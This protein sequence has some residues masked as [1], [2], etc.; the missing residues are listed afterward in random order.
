MLG[1]F[2]LGRGGVARIYV[3]VTAALLVIGM[4]T[5]PSD[6]RRYA[7]LYA[8]GAIAMAICTWFLVQD[9]NASIHDGRVQ[10]SHDLM[11]ARFCGLPKH[12]LLV[13]WGDLYFQYN[14]LY[15]QNAGAAQGCNLHLYSV[16]SLQLAPYSTDNL[17]Q[18]TGY[19]SVVEAL[20]NGRT[21]YMYTRPYELSF[22]E[23]YLAEHYG[24]KLTYSVAT[25][26]Y[27]NLNVYAVQATP[28]S[29][30]PAPP[31]G[32]PSNEM[33]WPKRTVFLNQ[34]LGR[35]R[36]NLGEP[37]RGRRMRATTSV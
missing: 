20:L 34:M 36:G 13:I 14:T 17:Y 22:L 37:F 6:G 25:S 2:V 4:L 32:W 16:A 18:A 5:L 3:P 35:Y 28:A 9:W 33:G 19:R 30:H 7:I 10:R 24:S 21:L 27:K 29:P 8:M 23:T 26:A 15:D 31:V 11:T 12:D 1:L